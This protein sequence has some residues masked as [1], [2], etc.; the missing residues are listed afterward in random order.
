MAG[1]PRY[2]IVDTIASGDFAVVY[3]ARDREL[4]R[5]VAIKQIHQQF[6][7]D[8][9]QLERYWKEAQLL[10]SLQH[11]HIVTIYDLDRSRGWLILELM[12][13]SLRQTLDAGPIDLDYLRVALAGCLSALSFLHSNGVIHGDLK[14]SNLL[15]DSQARVKLGDFGLARRASSEEGSL[16]KGTTKY[17]AP[18]LVAP[19]FGPVGPPSDLYSLGF[20]AYELI[21]GPQFE[22]LFPGLGTFGR[23]RQIAWM[24]WHAAADRQL[25]EIGR[26]LE[27]VPAD[28][29][30]IVQRMV[31]KDQSQRYS[32]AA[33][34]LRDLKTDPAMIDAPPPAEEDAEELARREAEAKRKRRVRIGAIC[35]LAVSAVLSVF[36][37]LPGG[38]EEVAGPPPPTR[39]EV[40]NTYPDE[41]V[42]QVR[43]TEGEKE[44]QAAELTIR[45]ND[46]FFVNEKAGTFRDL[47]T[48]DELV[49]K[50]LIEDE[51]KRRI[52]QYHAYRPEE[53]VGRIAKVEPELGRILL[54]IE[55]GPQKG[56]QIAIAVPSDLG[57]R[58]RITFNGAEQ[59]DD[60]A[61]Q[62]GD[63]QADD[64]VT[65]R[66]RGTETGREATQLAVLRVVTFDGIVR[67]YDSDTY[68][69]TVAQ[70][71]ASDADVVT[72]PVAAECEVTINDRRFIEQQIVKPSD[73][74]PGD[75]AT[76]AHDL[77]IVRVNAYRI[78]GD[79]GTIVR[80]DYP[81]RSM[82]VKLTGDA[83][84][85]QYL[86]KPDCDITLGGETVPLEDLRT[87]DIVDITHDTPDASRTPEALAIAARRPS[88]PN[89][90]AILIAV[91][92]YEDLLLA[93][94]DWPVADAAHLRDVLVK[95]F[96]VPPEQALLLANESLVRLEQGIPGL[97]SRTGAD[98]T[99]VV[100]CAAHAF[101]AP[102]GEIYIAPTNFDSKRI[103]ASGL[104]LQWLVD[105]LEKCSAKK[106][107]LLLDCAHEGSATQ[108]RNQPSTAEMLQTLKSEGGRAPLRTVTALASCQPGQRGHFWP[109]KNHSL[110]AHALA[111]GFSGDGDKN[112]DNRLEVTELFTFVKDTMAAGATKLATAQ[113]PQ[114]FLPDDRPPRLSDNARQAIRRLA[115]FLRQS[116]PDMD[117]VVQQY[118]EAKKLAGDEIDPDLIYGLLLI[119]ARERDEAFRHFEQL[120]LDNPKL[121]LPLQAIAWLRFEKRTY[122]PGVEELTELVSI[123]PERKAGKPLSE[124]I[125][126]LFYWMGQLREYSAT[127]PE[128]NYRAKEQSVARL[129]AAVE[130]CGDEAARFY[131]QGRARTQTVMRDYEKRMAAAQE[132]AESKRLKIER[133]RLVN[134]TRLPTD[135]IAQRILDGLD[136][137]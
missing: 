36:M 75:K 12:R 106:K 70:G 108:V 10:A 72:L 71:E 103:A 29:A 66:H 94:L 49:I 28:L 137:Y 101:Q 21:C 51:S 117:A 26:I 80:I 56:Q 113:A 121:I 52:T 37:L 102:E 41:R 82:Q 43:Y 46:Q 42:L 34:V 107:L 47:Q 129:D 44:G 84:E 114:L 124:E 6:L 118:D 123:L 45:G 69:L 92:D 1:V 4:G 95:R 27:G 131:E 135:D 40:L 31:A 62:V 32:S 54:A 60:R 65:V 7:S 97:L 58:N 15:V 2:E 96:A 18:E 120:K 14:P 116:K 30:M 104:S 111:E 87:G 105:Q 9:R 79:E 98:S 136:D 99:V 86:I 17:M 57:S 53:D 77:Q 134:Y 48:G 85:S 50:V 88:D 61:I 22:T 109:E 128:G 125:R 127:I 20:A 81:A 78:M 11:P 112:R 23:D 100:Y 35:A 39:A 74:R 5:E 33:D 64:R 8:P 115:S 122:T 119:V 38:A 16:L 130:A 24:M 132:E 55:E 91:E 67:A 89:R 126:E 110:F 68:E 63:L 83:S 19:Q 133:R 59:I 90:W 25:P 76:V 13:G 73:L 3:R 93:R